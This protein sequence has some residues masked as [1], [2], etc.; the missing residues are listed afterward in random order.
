MDWIKLLSTSSCLTSVYKLNI[1]L[2]SKHIQENVW[3]WICVKPAEQL[4]LW[5]GW[6]SCRQLSQGS[7]QAQMSHTPHKKIDGIKHISY[8]NYH[9]LIWVLSIWA[10]QWPNEPWQ[11]TFTSTDE[12]NPGK[13]IAN[14]KRITTKIDFLEMGFLLLVDCL[15][16][17]FCFLR[18]NFWQTS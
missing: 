12:S 18:E 4:L 17:S 14:T 10:K 7:S 15:N 11:F 8:I 9:I 5:R 16:E 3:I 13:K 6:R 2:S 1:F